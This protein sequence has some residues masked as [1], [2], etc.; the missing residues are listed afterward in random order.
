ME[1]GP[2]RWPR[3]LQLDQRRNVI[4]QT[5]FRKIRKQSIFIQ[6]SQRRYEGSFSSDLPHGQG[7]F[8][9]MDGSGYRGRFEEGLMTEDGEYIDSPVDVRK[10]KVEEFK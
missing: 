10:T 5:F 8:Y 2:P 9:W 7:E 4:A 3:I 6:I 1:V